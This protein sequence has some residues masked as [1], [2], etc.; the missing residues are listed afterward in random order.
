MSYYFNIYRDSIVLLSGTNESSLAAISVSKDI[1]MTYYGLPTDFT[2]DNYVDSS[3]STHASKVEP[4][5]DARYHMALVN[6]VLFNLTSKPIY[7][8]LYDNE[9]KK[10]RRD[11]N[12]SNIGT[13]KQHAY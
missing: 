9:V 8:E 7:M 12:K 2:V 3:A 10:C 11:L 4:D 6:H 1:H 5:L 13:L